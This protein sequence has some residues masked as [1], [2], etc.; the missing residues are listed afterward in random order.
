MD[1]T[2][3]NALANVSGVGSATKKNSSRTD[4]TIKVTTVTRIRGEM[5]QPF[6]KQRR[7]FEL[8]QSY[9]LKPRFWIPVSHEELGNKGVFRP[10]V[11][12]YERPCGSC[13]ELSCDW[14]TGLSLR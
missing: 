11:I 9:M 12:V 14:C 7:K 13:E 6:K 8:V 1:A 2:T 10:P 4:V 3:S 5:E